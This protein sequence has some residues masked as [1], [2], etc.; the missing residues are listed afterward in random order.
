[1]K[2]LI[3]LSLI[4]TVSVFAKDLP[5]QKRLQNSPYIKLEKSK[6]DQLRAQKNRH[7]EK[8]T[9]RYNYQHNGEVIRCESKGNRRAF[10]PADTRNGINF[11]RQISRTSC[12][13]NWGYDERGIWVDNG[14]R[15]EFSS[16]R[17]WSQ[18]D[19]YGNV[20]VCES[21][22]FQRNY[23]RA[24]LNQ[25]SVILIRQISKSSCQNNWG[26]DRGGVWVTNGCRAEFG[27]EDRFDRNRN[28]ITCSSVNGQFRMCRVDTRGGVEFVRQLSRSSCN[29][30][31]G[32]DQQGIWVAN[33]CRARFRVTPI[34]NYGN[35]GQYR[36]KKVSCSSKAYKRRFC[37]IPNHNGVELI[38]QRSR[39]S[40]QGNWGFN[41]NQ[42]WVTNGCRATFAV[43]ENRYNPN[44]P[45]NNG[46]GYNNDYGNNN[47]FGQ[48]NGFGNNN[49]TIVCESRGYKMKSCPIP[50]RSRVKLSRQLSKKSCRGN[51][52]YNGREIR[53]KNGCRAE[54]IILRN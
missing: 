39:S 38:K 51:W 48:N 40:C 46:Y 18:P 50:H 20:F 19:S 43:Y 12:D 53:V 35:N 3:Y 24:A 17:D 29:Y 10:C 44:D 31:W 25:R 13:Y 7:N 16:N 49:Q 9:E 14:C 26:Y 11:L 52:A 36:P 15:A 6:I 2:N 8:Y 34:N 45:H 27:L 33:G 41:E 54:F 42:I 4:F 22:N 5:T 30:N 28:E 37:K 47:G 21:R 32:Y 1:M 23:C